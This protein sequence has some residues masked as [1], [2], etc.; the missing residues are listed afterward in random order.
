VRQEWVSRW[1]STLIEAKERR[2]RGG[3]MG[4]DRGIIGKT[5]SLEI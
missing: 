2:K 3:G 4:V 1:R 5:I